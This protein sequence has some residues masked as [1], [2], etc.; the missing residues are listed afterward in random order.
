MVVLPLLSQTTEDLLLEVNSN[1]SSLMNVK[2]LASPLLSQPTPH[3]FM[4]LKPHKRLLLKMIYRKGK[5]ILITGNIGSLFTIDLIRLIYHVAK[6]KISFRSY[7]N[8]IPVGTYTYL[9]SVSIP[10]YVLTKHEKIRKISISLSYTGY[11][12]M[13]NYVEFVNGGAMYFV[14]KTFFGEAVPITD[15]EFY[16]PHLNNETNPALSEIIDIINSEGN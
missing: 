4:F 16:L 13:K 8:L 7:I 9:Q 6:N 11:Y 3:I 15:G 5:Q 2:S 12:L 14:D 1:P 10:L